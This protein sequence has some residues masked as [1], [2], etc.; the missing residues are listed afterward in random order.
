MKTASER[1]RERNEAM[2]AKAEAEGWQGFGALVEDAD[3]WAESKVFTADDLDRYLA[4]SMYSDMYKDANGFRPRADLSR[5]SMEILEEE[6]K[7]L[8]DRIQE[9]IAEERAEREL[10][11]DSW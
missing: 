5:W 3:F 1:A 8:S 9:Q 11:R 2:A 4:E 10:D 6:I 7:K